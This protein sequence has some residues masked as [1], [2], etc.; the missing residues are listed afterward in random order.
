MLF[1][2]GHSSSLQTSFRTLMAYAGCCVAVLIG[3]DGATPSYNDAGTNTHKQPSQHDSRGSYGLSIASMYITHLS[4]MA[5]DLRYADR[6]HSS[7][8]GRFPFKIMKFPFKIMNF[9][10]K[11]MNVVFKM[12]DF[13]AGSQSAAEMG[14][15]WRRKVKGSM[16]E[17]VDA[18]IRAQNIKS[19]A[20]GFVTS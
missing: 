13:G 7:R 15:E 10:T 11:L 4:D 18:L 20:Q 14:D 3:G 17:R 16:R 9:L 2:Y 6:R 12:S 5:A 8:S 19:G 1:N